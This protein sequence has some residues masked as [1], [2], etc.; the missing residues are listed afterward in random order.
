[1]EKRTGPVIVAIV[2]LLVIWQILALVIGQEIIL[3]APWGVVT[4]LVGLVPQAFFWATIGH[5]LSRILA[6]F[7][8]AFGIGL[9][10]AWLGSYNRWV[11]G[12]CTTL[13]R[14]IRS[15]P[16]VSIIIL[17]LIWATASGLGLWVSFLMVVPIVYVNAE[18]G[19]AAR[20][21]QLGE[22]ATVFGLSAAR[23]WWAIS[24]PA[25]LPYLSAATRVGVGLAWKAGVSAEV[26]G[27][28]RGSIGERLY[29]AKI[30]L[31]TADLFAWTVVIVALSYLG[32]RLALGGLRRAERVLGRYGA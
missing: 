12:F 28:P 18:E 29:Q 11:A 17:L 5:S 21:P 16:V 1:M 30:F 19:F 24:L 27:L 22:M 26:I 6:G 20:D 4:T 13:M 7:L 23:R 3:V 25:L 2:M 9:L 10:L 14:V 31:A 8:L 32:E 15:I